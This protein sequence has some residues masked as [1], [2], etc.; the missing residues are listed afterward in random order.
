MTA[1]PDVFY[2]TVP[3]TSTS[4]T[5]PSSCSGRTRSAS[6]ST[7][8]TRAAPRPSSAG[9]RTGS[10]RSGWRSCSC[11]SFRAREAGPAHARADLPVV[12]RV[13]PLL[14][15]RGATRRPR[16]R[17]LYRLRDLPARARPPHLPCAREGVDRR[18]RAGPV[19]RGGAHEPPVRGCV[20][21]LL[22][23]PVWAGG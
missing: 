23:V 12:D 17:G 6:Y 22:R 13:G 20:S 3:V 14:D 9:R 2:S 11:V 5:T 7:S 1:A 15:C 19:L 10:S 21:P 16:G 18:A 4:H 8:P